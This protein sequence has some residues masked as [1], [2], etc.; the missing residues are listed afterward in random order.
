M[1]ENNS[2]FTVANSKCTKNA[3]LSWQVSI[4]IEV[5]DKDNYYWF[6]L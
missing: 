1:Y 3:Y 5:T 2:T 6:L 4:K